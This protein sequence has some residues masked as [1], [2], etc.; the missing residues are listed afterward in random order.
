MQNDI[1]QGQKKKKEDLL[2]SGL[3][4]CEEPNTLIYSFM[5]YN[6]K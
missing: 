4:V 5:F 3:E 6:L 2:A 1:F